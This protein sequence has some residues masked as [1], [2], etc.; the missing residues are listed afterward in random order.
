MSY[1]LLRLLCW[2]VLTLLLI[3]LLICAGLFLWQRSLLYFPQ[4]S[5]YRDAAHTLMLPVA[6]ATL[7]VTTEVRPGPRALIYFG[8]NAE[9]VSLNLATFAQAFPDRAIYLLHY[10]GYGQS[11]GEPGEAALQQDALALFDQVAQQHQDIA[12]IGRSLGSGVATWLAS[13][14]PVSR[15]V[16]VTPYDSIEAVAAGQYPYVP[17]SWLL[18]DKYLSWR[19]APA[20]TAPTLLL[21]AAND[22][23]IPPSHSQRLL[24]AFRPG[25]AQLTTLADTDHASISTSP[26]YLP[27]LQ[28]GI[29]S[30]P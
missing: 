25:V 2:S 18:R 6:G 17:V 3:Y 29:G 1:P 19:D 16:L 10:R 22:R 4:P 30:P 5:H 20:I 27:L 9:D 26:H 12:V 13:Q 24:Q 28:Q 14:R 15:L 7:Q 8:G 23:L 11:S 21:V